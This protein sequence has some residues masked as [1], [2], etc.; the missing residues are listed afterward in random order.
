MRI[1]MLC[2]QCKLSVMKNGSRSCHLTI[3]YPGRGGERSSGLRIPFVSCYCLW[4]FFLPLKGTSCQHCIT[5][6]NPC[7]TYVTMW[8]ELFFTSWSYR[9]APGYTVIVCV[10][11]G[12]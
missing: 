7:V 10:R 2:V 4:S 12:Q 5:Y 9:Y 1:F 8:L 3:N 6:V 11:T